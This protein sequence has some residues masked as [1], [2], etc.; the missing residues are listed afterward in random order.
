MV[1][2]LKG[3]NCVA[4][5]QSRDDHIVKLIQSGTAFTRRQIEQII[6]PKR[7]SSKRIAQHSLTRLCAQERIKQWKRA[8]QLPSIYYARKPKQLDHVLLV[9]EVYCALLSQKKSWYSI[10]W[11]WR[12]SILGGMVVAD[13]M[14]SIYLDPDRKDRRVV[15]VEVERNPSKR[16]DKPEQYQKV[17][18][19]DWVNEE[20]S[21]IKG[22]T[23]IFPTILIVTDHD[24]TIKS[25]LNFIVAS[26]DDV[27]KD[28]Y[29][30]L[31]R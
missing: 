11:K 22:N 9:N 6:I 25:D 4:F 2:K 29:G 27:Q 13:A 5:G 12:Y 1:N 16:F 20:W 21:V 7:K 3:T 31:R 8:P 23:A 10:E 19:A 15:F 18:D 14:A 26:I 17:Y 30:L 24:L 28:I